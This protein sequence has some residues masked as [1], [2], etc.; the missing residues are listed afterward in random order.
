MNNNDNC[1]IGRFYAGIASLIIILGAFHIKGMWVCYELCIILWLF[2]L[3]VLLGHC[4][5]APKWLRCSAFIL[6]LGLVVCNAIPSLEMSFPK[7]NW[8]VLGYMLLGLS[9]PKDNQSETMT[10]KV[11]CFLCILFGFIYCACVFLSQRTGIAVYECPG[12]LSGR[13]H[14][15]V[16]SLTIAPLLGLNYCFLQL[17]S[18]EKIQTLMDN[19]VIKWE[20]IIVCA[21]AFIICIA[22]CFLTSLRGYYL[23]QLALCPMVIIIIDFIAGKIKVKRTNKQK[24]A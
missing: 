23:F 2:W 11:S 5:D 15:W 3:G 8:F 7:I 10:L 19:K 21:V 14:N 20:C 17:A 9:V 4:I 12:E 16:Y 18:N 1:L 13:I 24:N 22:K 6:G